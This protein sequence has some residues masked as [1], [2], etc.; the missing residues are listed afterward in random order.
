MIPTNER[1]FRGGGNIFDK[2][3]RL[4]RRVREGYVCVCSRL[5]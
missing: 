5:H 1:G 3:G 2:T 4:S